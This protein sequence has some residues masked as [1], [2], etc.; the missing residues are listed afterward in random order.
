[1]LTLFVKLDWSPGMCQ[2]S[3][4]SA[5][6]ASSSPIPR[7]TLCGPGAGAQPSPHSCLTESIH[8]ELSLN[9][10]TWVSCCSVWIAWRIEEISAGSVRKP[11]HTHIPC[12][13]LMNQ[14]KPWGEPHIPF[15][16]RRVP[17][18]IYLEALQRWGSFLPLL[19]QFLLVLQLWL[20]GMRW[21]QT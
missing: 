12:L 18:L 20:S 19:F 11:P 13:H 4:K 9:L 1:M 8:R 21:P 5:S 14:G 15:Q 3:Y 16:P 6:V 10:L 2:P 17:S 7:K